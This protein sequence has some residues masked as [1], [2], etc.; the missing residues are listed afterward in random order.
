VTHALPVFLLAGG[1]GTRIAEE[2]RDI[3]KCMIDI[4]G[5]PFIAYVLENIKKFGFEQV[6]ILAGHLAEPMINY[7]GNGEA[8]GLRVE[9]SLDGEQ[10]LGTGGAIKKA[11]HFAKDDFVVTYADSYL[12]Y[13]WTPIVEHYSRIGSQSL[14]SVYRNVDATDK[15]NIVFHNGKITSYRKV[16][17][18][19]DHT[20]IDW[21]VS[22]FLTKTFEKYP[23]TQWDL[24]EYL[25]DRIAQNALDGFA[26]PQK[27]FEIGTPQSLEQFRQYM[28]EMA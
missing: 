9:Y 18:T 15:S 14:V 7:V 8:F 2:Y 3:P 26:V 1:L 10:L 24:S 6:V 27:Y 13:D 20:Y 23:H 25:L 17:Q 28:R 19:P 12:E 5:K 22:I 11:L 16:G 21:G 4:N